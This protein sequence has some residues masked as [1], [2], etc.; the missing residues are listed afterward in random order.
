[1][2]ELFRTINIS[3][4]EEHWQEALDESAGAGDAGRIPALDAAGKLDPSMMPSGVGAEVV[5]APSSESMAAGDFV[6][7][8]NDGGTI[9][10]RLA[11]AD[12]GRPA[13]GYVKAAVT[14]PAN[15]TV[16]PLGTI[17]TDL[18]GLTLDAVY[19]L[20]KTPG[21]VVT[22]ISGHGDTDIVQRIGKA[23]SATAI[24]T[25]PNIPASIKLN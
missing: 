20:G 17:N 16:Y 9:K 11:D 5:V 14:S 6:N 1:M 3:T 13:D 22:D 2:A 24:L 21:A 15:A 19:Y 18:S 7:R 25:E 8:W 4:G 10:Y 23:I 12:N